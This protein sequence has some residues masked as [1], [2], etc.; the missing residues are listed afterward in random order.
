MGM[1]GMCAGVCGCAQVCVGVRRYVQVC[2]GVRG[3]A[4]VC[5][6]VRRCVRVCAVVPGCAQVCMGVW[7][8]CEGVG[9][10]V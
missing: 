2:A 5:Q 6:G 1:C 3:C 10:S 9:E 4:R 8:V 7:W